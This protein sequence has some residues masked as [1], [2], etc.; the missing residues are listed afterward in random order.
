LRLTVA[1][2]ED[3]NQSSPNSIK[4][5][6]AQISPNPPSGS[7]VNGIFQAVVPAPLQINTKAGL[8]SEAE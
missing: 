6:H 3:S 5:L 1:A 2:G 7:T 8:L 4:A